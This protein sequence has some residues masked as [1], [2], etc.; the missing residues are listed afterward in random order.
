MKKNYLAAVAVAAATLFSA[1]AHAGYYV[2][3]SFD[4]GD[5]LVSIDINHVGDTNVNPWRSLA[6]SWSLATPPKARGNAEIADGQLDIDNSGDDIGVVT[7]GWDIP[8][9]A[10]S[11]AVTGLQFLFTILQSDGNPTIAKIYQD[12][13]LMSMDSIPPNSKNS[14]YGVKLDSSSWDGTT[15]HRLELVLTGAPGWDLSLDQL[16]LLYDDSVPNKV[17]EPSSLALLSLGLLGL[18]AARRRSRK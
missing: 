8:A 16:G 11:G 15:A 13:I 17:P 1:S 14:D 5:Q 12:G 7:L 6:M 9:A 18:G 4:Q 2:I 10:F 3:D